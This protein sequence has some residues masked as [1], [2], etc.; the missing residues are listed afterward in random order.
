VAMGYRASCSGNDSFAKGYQVDVA[1]DFAAGFGYDTTVN[2]NTAYGLGV[3]ISIT[4]NSTSTAAIGEYHTVNAPQS[5]VAGSTHVV[6]NDGA[7]LVAGYAHQVGGQAGATFGAFNLNNAH[8]GITSGR[9]NNMNIAYANS[10]GLNNTANATISTS[11]G[12]FL[13]TQAFAEVVLG[14]C[15]ERNITYNA[16]HW[17]DTDPIFRVG[18]GQSG[19]NPAIPGDLG[20]LSTAQICQDSVDGLKLL[21]NGDLHIYKNAYAQSFVVT[22]DRSAKKDITPLEPVLDRVKRIEPV[23]YRFSRDAPEYDVLR[24]GLIAQDMEELFPELVTRQT[25]GKLGLSYG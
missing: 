19:Y 12:F 16:T 18:I 25:N 23:H 13:D 7:C 21:K 15:N 3:G 14:Q 20:S 22:S 5:L 2:A 11:I 24:I 1:G 6:N 17:I 10:F 8:F 9:N 4:I